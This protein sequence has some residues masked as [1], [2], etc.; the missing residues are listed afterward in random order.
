MVKVKTAILM[1]IFLATLM[2][3][4]AATPWDGEERSGYSF[5]PREGVRAPESGA[6][7]I[8]VEIFT[9]YLFPFEVLALVLL[10]A[11]I[12][13]IYIARKELPK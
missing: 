6:G 1:L 13:A 9:I 10:A 5:E 8:G 7:D 4:I 12:G 2:I 11:M 3:F